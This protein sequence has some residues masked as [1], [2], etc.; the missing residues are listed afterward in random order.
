MANTVTKERL[1]LTN[2]NPKNMPH[3]I[4]KYSPK[5]KHRVLFTEIN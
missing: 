5:L 3:K 1:Y 2:K 4:K